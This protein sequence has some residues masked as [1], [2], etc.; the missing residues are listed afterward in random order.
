MLP[1]VNYGNSLND[2]YGTE[3]QRLHFL[4]MPYI[5]FK[6]THLHITV[7]GILIEKDWIWFTDTDMIRHC[8]IE[9]KNKYGHKGENKKLEIPLSEF[10]TLVLS[11]VYIFFPIEG[12]WDVPLSHFR[13]PVCHWLIYILFISESQDSLE[14][15]MANLQKV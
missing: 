1:D 5:H 2:S 11:S 7:C 6:S 15:F 10:V 4:C 12:S 9:K 14:K 8:E 3:M 13:E